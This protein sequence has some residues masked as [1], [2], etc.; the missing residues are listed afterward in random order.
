MFIVWPSPL[1]GGDGCP[2][3]W[4]YRKSK[5]GCCDLSFLESA[6]ELLD[7][8]ESHLPQC[9]GHPVHSLYWHRYYSKYTRVKGTHLLSQKQVLMGMLEYHWISDISTLWNC[10]CIMFEHLVEQ[11]SALETVASVVDIV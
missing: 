10:T 5:N 4:F 2:K 7:Y 9:E 3:F 6:P 1:P 11:K 8:H